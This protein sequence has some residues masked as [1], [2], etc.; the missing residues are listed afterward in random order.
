[1]TL[2]VRLNTPGQADGVAGL[3]VNGK[4][5][6]YQKMIWRLQP[7]TMIT[8]ARRGALLGAGKGKRVPRQAGPP[9]PALTPLAAAGPPLSAAASPVA[10]CRPCW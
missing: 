1:M 9:A 8:Q 3:G 5:V 7:D 4:Y 10:L 6:E 2:R